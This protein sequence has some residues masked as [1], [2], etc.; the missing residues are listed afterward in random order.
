[1][2]DEIVWR[3]PP[4]VLNHL[5]RIPTDLPV[6]LL[7]RH[8]VRD[9]L[10]P[11]DAGYALPITGIGRRLAV[12]LGEK[13]R[14]RLKALHASPL[15]RCVQTAEALQHGAGT[16]YGIVEDRLLGDPGVFVL[17]GYR[18]WPNWEQR[19]HEGVM[20]HLVSST[21][22]LPGM[23]GPD[24][25]AR[26]LVHHM[27]AVAG[28]TPGIHVF[29]THDS[30]VTATAARF[31]GQALGTSDW[32][33]YLEGAFF[34]QCREGLHTLYRENEARRDPGPLCTLGESD[35]IEFARRVIAAT[36]GLDSG[37][38]FFLA[39][40]AFKTLLSGRPP[41]DLDL[42]APSQ[43]DRDALLSVLAE[44]GARSLRTGK[45][46]QAFELAGRIIEVPYNVEQST[47]EERLEH[48]DIGLSAVG[49]EHQSDGSWRAC[50]HP[51]A[52]E[53]ERRQEVL[54]LKPLVNW[55]HCLMT[56]ERMR[57]YA[58][59]LGYTVPPEEEAEI[60]KVFAA[61]PSDIQ[62]GMK[63]RFAGSTK[64]GFGVG[65]ELA[66]RFR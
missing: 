49:V 42:W 7:L 3:I 59:E 1:M 6:V 15:L 28:G 64:G 43:N 16:N 12:E 41:R 20:Q 11:G 60:W 47:L 17:D 57:R 48:F 31:L 18:A 19:G 38:R 25:A 5:E 33:W 50:I 22:A 13:L 56:L 21:Q 30:L 2:N 36:I 55:K 39:G 23:A 29:V 24:E 46:N 53:S 8:S 10:P 63:K 51:L 66:C 27:L 9:Y 32:P 61:Q 62:A 65:D 52:K 14:G 34:W 54:L 26:F 35:V 37:V 4:S 58:N 44:R 45:Y 40:G